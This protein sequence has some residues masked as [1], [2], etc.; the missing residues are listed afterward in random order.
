MPAMPVHV[1][2]ACVSC[3][4]GLLV[5]AAALDR[6]GPLPKKPSTPSSCRV[7]RG[8]GAGVRVYQVRGHWYIQA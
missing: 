2:L 1:C 8:C 4:F 6:G 3:M 5:H 7:L